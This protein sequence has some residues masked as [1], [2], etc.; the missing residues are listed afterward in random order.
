MKHLLISVIFATFIIPAIAARDRNPRR[1][2]KRMLLL[3]L[4][5]NLLYAAHVAFVHATY[6]LP[7]AEMNR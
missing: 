6:V 1:G 4:V 5:F 7:P 3:F 2:A